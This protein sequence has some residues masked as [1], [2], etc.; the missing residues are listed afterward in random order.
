[1]RGGKTGRGERVRRVSLDGVPTSSLTLPVRRLTRADLP[2]ALDLAADRSWAREAHKWRLLL[3]A[4]TGY[5]IDAPADDPVGGL[6]GAFVLTPYPGYRCVSMV[7]VARRH[8]RRGLGERLMRHAIAESGD[9]VVFLSATANGRPLYEKLG[10]TAVGAV[11]TLQGPFTG[12]DPGQGD[13]FQDEGHGRDGVR[14]RPATAA[15]MPGLLALDRPVFGTDRTELLARLPSFADRLAVAQAPDGHL[16]GY[17]ASWPNVTTTVIGPVVAQDLRTARALISHL[18]AAA[19]L[20]LRYDVDDRHPELAGWL[21][22]RGLSGEFRCT[23][24]VR[25]APDLPGDIS[26]RF[27]PYSVALG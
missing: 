16:T 9:A 20:P 19:T 5:G 15:D 24:M 23:L 18:G 14:V 27:A 6:I 8:E 11:T 10:F 22:S 13:T 4:G 25:G 26:R 12:A 3:S 1:M 2:T 17:A 7:L 21:R